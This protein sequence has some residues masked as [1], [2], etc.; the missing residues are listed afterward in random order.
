M[1]NEIL[2]GYRGILAYWVFI[3]HVQINAK[4]DSDYNYFFITG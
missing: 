4:L 3:H 1:Y 2:D